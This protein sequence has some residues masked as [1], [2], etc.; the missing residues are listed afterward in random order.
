MDATRRTV[1]GILAVTI[2]LATAFALG[3][4]TAPSAALEPPPAEPVHLTF[5]PTPDIQLV[6]ATLDAALNTWIDTVSETANTRSA[7]APGT[8]PPAADASTAD[9]WDALAACETGGDWATSTGNGFYGG[10]QF[11]A[12]TW[13]SMG[14]LDYA[15]S[16]DQATKEQQIDVAEKVL[17]AVGWRAWPGCSSKLGWR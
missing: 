17:A 12:S 4:C 8:V 15:P 3:R 7:A 14:G 1:A 13:T 2:I 5:R 6:D 11:A 16:A 9:R 10:L